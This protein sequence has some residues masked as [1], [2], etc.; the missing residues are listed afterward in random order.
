MLYDRRTRC[1]TKAGRG[2]RISFRRMTT[3]IRTWTN[4]SAEDRARICQWMIRAKLKDLRWGGYRLL[5]AKCGDEATRDCH[6][7]WWHTLAF[8]VVVV[9]VK[10]PDTSLN[11]FYSTSLRAHLPYRIISHSQHRLLRHYHTQRH[12]PT[13]SHSHRAECPPDCRR[14]SRDPSLSQGPDR[15]LLFQYH[16][17]AWPSIFPYR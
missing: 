3:A 17:R 10:S 11:P 15:L 6:C 5:M 12:S 1:L 9:Q 7:H 13:D 8:V 14:S 2:A 16:G 4:E